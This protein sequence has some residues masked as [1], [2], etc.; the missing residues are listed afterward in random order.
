MKQ[1]LLPLTVLGAFAF[2][3]S[4]AS[5]S[6]ST[7]YVQQVPNDLVLSPAADDVLL[8]QHCY[9]TPRYYGRGYSGP[10]YY[11]RSNR[12]FRPYGYGGGIYRGYGGY[13][14]YSA[15]YGNGPRAGIGLYIGF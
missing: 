5:A 10:A 2:T 13:G 6:H 7:S 4:S 8:A 11:G 14:R 15:R 12:S 1:L 9:R 3:N